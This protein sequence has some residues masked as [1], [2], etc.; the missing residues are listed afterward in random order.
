LYDL[1][2]VALFKFLTLHSNDSIKP[3]ESC[4]MKMGRRHLPID[5]FFLGD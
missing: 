1:K 3:D 4:L 5:G 2:E